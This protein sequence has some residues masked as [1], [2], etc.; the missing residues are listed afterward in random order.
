M[1]ILILGGTV[2]LSREIARQAL[3]R[4]HEVTCV[5]RGDGIP[6]VA[7]HVR[8][9]RAAATDPAAPAW[10]A[11]AAQ[12]W[13]AVVD[14]AR[15][16]SW[17][18]TAVTALADAAAHWTFVS[19]INVYADLSRPGASADGAVLVEPPTDG[20][21][22][23]D[24]DPDAYGRN[25][26]ACEQAVQAAFD[27]RA[28]IVRPGLIVGPGDPTGRF[29][30]WPVRAARGG[31]LLAPAPAYEPVQV[32]DVRD[33]AAGI[34]D[35]AEAG[36]T[37]IVDGVGPVLARAEF[38]AQVIAGVGGGAEAVW[39]DP[40]WLQAR[41]VAPWSG[42]RSIALWLPADTLPQLAGM[43][44]RDAAPAQAAGI[45]ARPLADTARD[46]LAWTQATPD[47]AATGLTAEEEA[48]LVAELG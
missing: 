42:P 25:K 15:I 35:A 9:D 18:R 11:L 2:F 1:R 10:R 33:L 36:R 30:S 34:L 20:D 26:V 24:G 7:T 5:S 14:V 32:I 39:A 22:D 4:G 37:G 13:D 31:R 21:L 44:A 38:V 41:D 46:T 8:I 6:D 3:E 19:T 27:G 28:F 48:A 29:T 43:I 12:R 40:A 16:P 23:D 45:H 47:A 17:V